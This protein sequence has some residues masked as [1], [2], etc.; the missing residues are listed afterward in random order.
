MR[1]TVCTLFEGDYHF[2]VGALVNSLYYHG[3][4]GVFWAGYRGALPVWAHPLREAGGYQE[5]AVAKDCV[6]RFIPLDTYKHLNNYKPDFML[7]LWE[8]HCPEAETLFY[9]DP[10]I[11]IKCRWSFFEEWASRG[12]ALCE[13]MYNL[14]PAD[15]PFRLAWRE[16]AEN[17]GFACSR[18][19]QR[20]F[21]AGFVGLR[22][23]D[24]DV[25]RLWQTLMTAAEQ[26]GLFDCRRMWMD[27]HAFPHLRND[28]D[29]LNLALMVGATPLST[30]GADGMDF[31]PGIFMSHA[32]AVTKPWRKPMLPK[33][34]NG[35]PPTR[36]D[37]GFWQHVEAPI[38]LYSKPHLLWRRIDLL[39]GSAVGRLIS[40]APGG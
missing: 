1:S 22:Q 9:I 24:R 32:A 7:R 8:S 35:V 14:M 12:L 36:A 3:F 15:H 37:K 40:R 21:N 28:Q 5:F 27:Q 30:I 6:I 19:L 31:I 25:L 38:R 10:D 26:Q 2:G 11:T 23:G 4:R 17:S 33:A 34:L 18:E 29:V 13:D 16:F 20:Y 39:M